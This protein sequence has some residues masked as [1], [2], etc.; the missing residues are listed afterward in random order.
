MQCINLFEANGPSVP[1]EKPRVLRS[2]DQVQAFRDA[3]ESYGR[4]SVWLDLGGCGQG[5]LNLLIRLVLTQ[6]VQRPDRRRNR[7]NERELQQQANDAGERAAYGEELQPPPAYWLSVCCLDSRR[8]GRHPAQQDGRAQRHPFRH[9]P[10][11]Y[12]NALPFRRRATIHEN[13]IRALPTIVRSAHGSNLNGTMLGFHNDRV[14]G[15]PPKDW[16]PHP[17]PALAAGQPPK[18]RK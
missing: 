11:R 8:F 17:A 12:A 4:G 16:S 5:V 3:Q 1:Y 7:T 2:V 15:I 18:G 10:F 14:H 13:A 9:E 6:G